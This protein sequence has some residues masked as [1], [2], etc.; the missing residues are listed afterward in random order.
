MTPIT[1]PKL[2]PKLG[3]LE[4][5]VA[6]GGEPGKPVVG[7]AVVNDSVSEEYEVENEVSVI[8]TVVSPGVV[9]VKMGEESDV[10]DDVC[11]EAAGWLELVDVSVA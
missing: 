7:S 4:G 11:V 1:P 2:S 10:I 9:D 5:A 6:L 3:P 8:E